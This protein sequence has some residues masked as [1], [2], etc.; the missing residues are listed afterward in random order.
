MEGEKKTNNQL[1]TKKSCVNTRVPLRR[2]FT[3]DRKP[4]IANDEMEL[5]IFPKLLAAKINIEVL[6]NYMHAHQ[7][8]F[9]EKNQIEVVAK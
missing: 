7:M 1:K 9:E 5:L 8:D 6:F 4:T 2:A 3:C